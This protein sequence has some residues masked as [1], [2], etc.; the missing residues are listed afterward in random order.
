LSCKSYGAETRIGGDV[1]NTIVSIA[2]G[3]EEIITPLELTL[4]LYDMGSEIEPKKIEE[5]LLSKY[6]SMC[7]NPAHV[8]I[9]SHTAVDE[10]I[11]E[12]ADIRLDKAFLQTAYDNIKKFRQEQDPGKK[13]KKKKD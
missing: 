8:K 9:L 12:C 5:M 13:Q 7:G 2:C 1:R 3:W 4:E 6:A 11:H 10:L